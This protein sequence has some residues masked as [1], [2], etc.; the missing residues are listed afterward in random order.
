MKRLFTLD[1]Q[2]YDSCK[3][4]INRC[5]VRAVIIR[6]GRLAMQVNPAG[7]YKIPGGGPEDDET[8]MEALRREVLEE[9]GLHVR[10]D[11]VRPIGEVLE[12][13]ADIFNPSYKFV[14]TS[15][16]YFCDAEDTGDEPM[17]TKS[18]I[19]NGYTFVWETPE[20]ILK[21]YTQKPRRDRD[22]EFIRILPQLLREDPG[23]G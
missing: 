11:T 2:N 23:E 19:R 20:E 18:E 4:V 17:L 10:M 22:M 21:N 3:S 15:Y 7:H 16:F 14:R 9:T 8:L 13:R 1:E 12:M 5:T 6:D